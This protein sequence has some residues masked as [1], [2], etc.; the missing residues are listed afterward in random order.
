MIGLTGQVII[1]MKPGPPQYFEFWAFSVFCTLGIFSRSSAE[2]CARMK[3][4]TSRRNVQHRIHIYVY[5]SVNPRTSILVLDEAEN[6]DAELS[7]AVA[8]PLNSFFE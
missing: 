2:A 8:A 5:T 6:S 1:L 7:D 4:V 3:H